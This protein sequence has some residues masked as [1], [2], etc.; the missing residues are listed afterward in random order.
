MLSKV[1]KLRTDGHLS[2]KPW[3]FDGKPHGGFYTQEDIQ[4]IINYATDRHIRIVPEIEMPGHA[5]AAISSYPQL[6]VFPEKQKNLKPWTHWGVSEHIFAPRTET[7]A[8]L[9]DVLF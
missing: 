5:R 4:E 9:Q 3:R 1:E 7:I 6:G 8:F 2:R